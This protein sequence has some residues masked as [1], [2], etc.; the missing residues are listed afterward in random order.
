MADTSK[1]WELLGRSVKWEEVVR[2]GPKIVEAARILYENS[3]QRQQ[4]SG[5]SAPGPDV[6]AGRLADLEAEV[7][8]LQENETQ[9]AALV[10]DIANQ[11]EA[12]TRSVDA[13][14]VRVQML[15]WLGGGAL[16]VGLTALVL[17]LLY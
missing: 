13:L 16:V 5:G 11:L 2:H 3:R 14:G 6:N 1:I 17:S 4:R 12:L 8:R 7:R 10:T 15:L 9:Q